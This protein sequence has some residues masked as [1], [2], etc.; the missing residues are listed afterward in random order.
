MLQRELLYM[1]ASTY[2]C[3]NDLKYYHTHG[4]SPNHLDA[5]KKWAHRLKYAQYQLIDGVLFRQ[6]YDKVLLRCLEKEDVEH[7]LTKLHDGPIGGHISRETTAHKVLR[8]GY[9]CPTLFKDAHAHA[10]AHNCQIC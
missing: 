9:Y 4:S 5:Q 8:E 6:N 2:S 10:H 1:P 7:I 3:Y